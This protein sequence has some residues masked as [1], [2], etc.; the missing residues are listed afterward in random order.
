MTQQLNIRLASPADRSVV[1]EAARRCDMKATQFGRLATLAA[2]RAV[3]A[4][5]VSWPWQPRTSRDGNET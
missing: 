5:G 1:E 4:E 2:A 3:L